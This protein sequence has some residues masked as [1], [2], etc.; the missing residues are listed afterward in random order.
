M[1]RLRRRGCSKVGSR[2]VIS[3]AP[4]CSSWRAAQIESSFNARPKK[5]S[6]FGTLV[7]S[8]DCVNGI[9]CS[10]PN[11]FKIH[12]LSLRIG[13]GVDDFFSFQD[14]NRE[15]LLPFFVL[16]SCWVMNLIHNPENFLDETASD[17]LVCITV[18]SSSNTLIGSWTWSRHLQQL[19]TEKNQRERE[20]TEHS[21]STMRTQLKKSCGCLMLLLG[22]S[23]L[24]VV[25]S[26]QIGQCS[27][28][29]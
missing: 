28:K 16:F 3:L 26:L 1:G 22:Y 14:H 27:T 12:V 24:S 13:F 15:L 8:N 19:R 11:G 6:G 10:T 23:W 29:I 17:G 20:R 18:P 7:M 5:L 21:V 2:I 9:I 4:W 25:S